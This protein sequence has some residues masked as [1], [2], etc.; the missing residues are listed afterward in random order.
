M[1]IQLKKYISC[2]HLDK[3]CNAIFQDKSTCLFSFLLKKLFIYIKKKV[4]SNKI[5]V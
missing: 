4:V 3:E 1:L 5:N 2:Y